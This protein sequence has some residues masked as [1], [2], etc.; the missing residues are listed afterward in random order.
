[1]K[2]T[3]NP[4]GDQAA[5]KI[6]EMLEIC[7]IDVLRFFLWM[8]RKGYFTS[9]PLHVAQ[10]A[11]K[12]VCTVARIEYLG[13]HF[14]CGY[15]GEQFKIICTI[16]PE[17]VAERLNKIPVEKQNHAWDYLLNEYGRAA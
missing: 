7:D 5:A 9:N 1:M 17:A 8:N 13:D 12:M 14:Y 10:L 11:I 16:K 2:I 3:L 4:I 15:E 6:D